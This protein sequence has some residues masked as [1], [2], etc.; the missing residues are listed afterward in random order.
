MRPICIRRMWLCEVG[1]PMQ[2]PENQ[3]CILHGS[4]RE[5][6]RTAYYQTRIYGK[7]FNWMQNDTVGRL[8]RLWIFR[9]MYTFS[10]IF[11]KWWL[12]FRKNL[13]ESIYINLSLCLTF[14][15]VFSLACAVVSFNLKAGFWYRHYCYDFNTIECDGV[16]RYGKMHILM[17]IC[18]NAWRIKILAFSIH[19]R[20][21]QNVTKFSRFTMANAFSTRNAVDFSYSFTFFFAWK[22]F[23]FFFSNSIKSNRVS[24][25]FVFPPL[26]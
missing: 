23:F 18:H 5:R 2:P 21:R 16:D 15:A 1:E 14:V 7:H 10:C 12:I 6:K 19:S 17:E 3:F 4:C 8:R 22:L 24:T 11:Q 26:R 9:R 20:K 13:A 25:A